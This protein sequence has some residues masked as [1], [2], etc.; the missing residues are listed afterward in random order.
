MNASP[1]ANL[2][3]TLQCNLKR[4][5]IQNKG[6]V[7]LVLES[8]SAVPED[9]RSLLF[10]NIILTGGT[11]RMKNFSI[12]LEEERP[13]GLGQGRHVL[14]AGSPPHGRSR[15]HVRVGTTYIG[16]VS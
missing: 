7:E 15:S 5:G 13:S 12:R 1:F 10:K 14:R 2:C 8:L 4:L 3:S 9:L 11:S 16:T 6:L